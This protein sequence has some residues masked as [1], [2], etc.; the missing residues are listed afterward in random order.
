MIRSACVIHTKINRQI[1]QR[2]DLCKKQTAYMQTAR[3]C[4][5]LQ[6]RDEEW[7][8]ID[9]DAGFAAEH[10]MQFFLCFTIS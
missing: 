7:A 8:Y 5:L 9:D 3:V 2:T 6:K 4:G 1:E 10:S